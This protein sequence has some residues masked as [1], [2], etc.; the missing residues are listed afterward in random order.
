MML[1][2]YHEHNE[3]QVLQI[4]KQ[5]KK[6]RLKRKIKNSIRCSFWFIIDRIIKK[7]FIKGQS[8]IYSRTSKYESRRYK[9][10]YFN[11]WF[12]LY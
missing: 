12:L 6:K 9:R 3:N 10:T 4:L 2:T 8:S 1:S 5:K 7:F 11:K